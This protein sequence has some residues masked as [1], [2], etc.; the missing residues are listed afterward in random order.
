LT[1]SSYSATLKPP[2]QAFPHTIQVFVDEPAHGE[3]NPQAEAVPV[4]VAAGQKVSGKIVIHPAFADQFQQIAVEIQS[5]TH[6]KVVQSIVT[7]ARNYLQGGACQPGVPVTLP[8]Q[9]TV[10]AYVRVYSG[11]LFQIELRLAVCVVST[12]SSAQISSVARAFSGDMVPARVYP[13][14]TVRLQLATMSSVP[15]LVSLHANQDG[16]LSQHRGTAALLCA[17]FAVLSLFCFPFAYM[18][19]DG[20]GPKEIR[21]F[22]VFPLCMGILGTV[23][24][25]V[26]S[27]RNFRFW[28]MERYLGVPRISANQRDE[29]TLDVQVQV[30]P[31]SPV[32]RAQASM[33]VLE[34]VYDM[35]SSSEV[36]HRHQVGEQSFEMGTQQGSGLYWGALRVPGPQE[37]PDSFHIANTQIVWYLEVQ[38]FLVNGRK[39]QAQLPLV[40]Q[41]PGVPKHPSQDVLVFD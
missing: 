11:Y 4:V 14:R 31:G 17:L 38:I 23:V 1:V 2:K 37:V 9:L 7:E 12:W 32:Q 8:F 10:P 34:K 15:T 21:E 35:R 39:W 33:Y 19:W 6:G 22:A 36:T 41:A 27:L 3:V 29:Y 40:A 16:W 5:H 24:G 13:A 20:G 18:M 26:I 28:R 30:L 25:M